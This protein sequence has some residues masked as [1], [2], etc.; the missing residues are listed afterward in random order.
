MRAEF[1]ANQMVTFLCSMA[2]L[3]L[4]Q[5]FTVGSMTWIIGPDGYREIMEAAQDHPA[6]TASTPATTSLILVP[7]RWVR[8]SIN[9]DDLIASIDRVTDRLAECQLL[10]DSVLDQSKAG[11]ISTCSATPFEATRFRSSDHGYSRGAHGA[12]PTT[13]CYRPVLG[14][15]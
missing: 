5:I 15:L 2:L 7:H 11:D 1:M 6:P 13:S 10:V 8:R 9:S 12:V 14:Q 4:G 3:E